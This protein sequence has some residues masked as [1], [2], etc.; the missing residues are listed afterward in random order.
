MGRGTTY[1]DV[2]PSLNVGFDLGDDQVVR[3]AAAKVLSRPN[4]GDMRASLGF[5][6]NNSGTPILTGSGG[7]PELKPFKATALD[8]S[9]EKY[10]G[11]KGYLSV[12]GFYKKLDTYILRVPTVFDFKPYVGAATPLPQTGPYKGSTMGLLDQPINGNGGNIKG[13]ELALNVPLSMVSSWLDGFGV[14]VNHSSTSSSVQLPTSGFS[15]ESVTPVTIPLPGLSKKVTNFRFYYEAHGLQVAVAQRKRSD[16]LGEIS[17]FQDNRQL[18]FIK[19]ETIVDF[20]VGYELQ[21]GYLKGLSVLFQANNLGNAEFKRYKEVPSNVIETVKYG[22]T[23][24][25]GINYKL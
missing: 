15:V 14:Q 6:L 17:D 19:G 5:S 1:T 18:T 13:I 11:K 10:F 7:N 2:L 3:L 24:L 12:A 4:M 23:Y 9:Y 8:L 21:S 16:F 25:M 22:K 20:Q